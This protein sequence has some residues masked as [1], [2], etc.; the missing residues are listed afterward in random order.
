MRKAI[1][2]EFI[3]L[4]VILFCSFP[5][6]GQVRPS[7][8]L[9]NVNVIGRD[10]KIQENVDVSMEGN[11]I[12]DV[13][14][15]LKPRR[16]QTVLDK[17]GKFVIPGLIDT[18]VQIGS[19]PGNRINR[20][21]LGEE[22]RI[23]WMHSMV[24]LGVTTAR[25]IQGDLTEH[26]GF[27]HFRTFNLL[28]SPWI[29][30]SGPTFTAVDGS[31]ANQYDLVATNTRVREVYEVADET[32]AIQK[33]REVAHNGADI[34]E[35]S[36]LEGPRWV[37]APRLKDD[38]LSLLTK[39]AHGHELKAF[40]WVGTNAEAKVAIERG[41]DV[42]E[43]LTE[44]VADQDLL[45]LMAEKKTAFVPSLI[46]QGYLMTEK[47]SPPAL[48]SYIAED[49]VARALS[50]LM[51]KSFQTGTIQV[52]NIRAALGHLVPEPPP[53]KPASDKAPTKPESDSP[54]GSR[55][56]SSPE[57][58]SDAAQKP[59]SD[60]G[61]QPNTGAGAAGSVPLSPAGSQQSAENARRPTV[62]E[63][64]RSQ[65]Q[66]ARENAK[67]MAAA[68][69]PIVVGTG[70][71]TL[72]DIPGAS[73]HTEMQL[74][75]DAGLTPLQALQAA[76]SN[77]AYALGKPSEFGAVEKGKLADVIV[78][79]ANPLEDIRNTTKIDTVIRGSWII[80]QD[81]PTQY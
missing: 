2:L 53:V 15:N 1:R 44:E 78:L 7:V 80:N 64:L 8:L 33:S 11:E 38:L 47:T 72:L 37:P 59:Q 63:A 69:I 39:E 6:L 49:Y 61:T 27:K 67:Q 22:Q 29:V 60:A 28:N 16:N 70:A 24:K 73:E 40:C 34:F 43:G 32:E 41:C 36:Y 58:K 48:L 42:L 30:V 14:P 12:L 52:G 50:P 13:G 79:E 19:S 31:P 66:R 77:A 35:I 23:A 57:N 54:S 26:T 51:K 3:I 17:S 71:G 76:T 18:R 74:L 46:A 10:G 5:A 21:E 81:D 75:V 25:F 56:G 65:E 62:G 20:A 4:A 55:A 68:G 9:K 45:H